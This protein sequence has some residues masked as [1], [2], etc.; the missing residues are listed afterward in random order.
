MTNKIAA[1]FDALLRRHYAD[2]SRSE[3]SNTARVETLFA[4]RYG[5]PAKPKNGQGG[6][7]AAVL[8]LS[9]DDGETLELGRT[10]NRSA[11]SSSA[12]ASRD[13]PFE[14]Y[15]MSVRPGDEVS[16]FQEYRVDILDPLIQNAPSTPRTAGY[17]APAPSV[18]PAPLAVPTHEKT[19]AP[20]PEELPAV[21]SK[22]PAVTGDDFMADMQSILSG[23]MVF[24]PVSKKMI[25][26]AQ[27][28]RP[29]TPAGVEPNGNSPPPD[30]GLAILDRIAQSM[31]YATAYDLGT[32]E[33]ENRFGD[34]DKIAELQEKAAADKK[35]RARGASAP[36]SSLVDPVRGTDFLQ[37]LDA[38]R[39]RRPGVSAAAEAPVGAEVMP[40]PALD[41]EI[42]SL[43]LAPSARKG[44]YALRQKHPAVR[45]TSGR[46]TRQEQAGAMAEAVLEHRNAI[47]ESFGPSEIRDACQ[48]WVDGNSEKTT[49]GEIQEGLAGILDRYTDEQ[50]A[51]F[52][53]HMA[54]LAFDVQPVAD[55]DPIKKTIQGLEGLDRFLEKEG[56]VGVWHAQFR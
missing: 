45:F 36:E 6:P 55:G 20:L 38:L 44:A 8:S 27:I 26:R 14:E 22:S 46:R 29:Q 52:S 18:K 1:A 37:D 16:A 40:V 32:V 3:A 50:L 48:Q 15:V 28:G 47:G 56:A 43:N 49:V 4:T 11:R 39:S 41:S 35:R 53:E 13:A 9:C 21:Q 23:Q 10:T 17:D 25:D 34:F 7:A 31:E 30:K 33:L 5:R 51:R 19:R 12:P 2:L 54:G 42:E 24:D